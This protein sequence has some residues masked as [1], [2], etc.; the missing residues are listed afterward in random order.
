MIVTD[1]TSAAA[2]NRY[3]YYPDRLVRM[4]GPG[5][6][7][8]MLA[9]ILEEPV[10]D[11]LIFGAMG[12]YFRRPR[13]KEVVDESIYDF[14]SR[15][16]DPRVANNI[17]SAVLHGIYAGDIKQLSARTLMAGMWY[18]EIAAGS[19]TAGSIAAMRAPPRIPNRELASWQTLEREGGEAVLPQMKDASV[20]AFKK[21]LGTLTDRL[22]EVLREQ[23]NVNLRTQT[24][25]TDIRR[26]E[27]TGGVSVHGPI[28][29]SN[30]TYC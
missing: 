4:P 19:L 17:V 9:R 18:D 16:L 2:Q 12:E 5:Q 23:P 11:G 10:F 7:F 29:T 1:K 22:V 30:V 26:N 8:S 13:P 24:Q 21:G 14:I 25:I 28:F 27:E 20:Y 15:R 6:G 3:V